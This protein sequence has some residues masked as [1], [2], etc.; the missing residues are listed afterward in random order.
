MH[1]HMHTH[2]I[3]LTTGTHICLLC[4]EAAQPHSRFCN[5][6]ATTPNDVPTCPC[7]V[8]LSGLGSYCSS[9]CA[10]IHGRNRRA[11]EPSLALAEAVEPADTLPLDVID[12]DDIDFIVTKSSKTPAQKLKETLASDIAAT[13]KSVSAPAA[14]AALRKNRKKVCTFCTNSTKGVCRCKRPLCGPCADDETG[15]CPHCADEAE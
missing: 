8:E 15:L 11:T 2:T 1:T 13:A 4:D 9:A 12:A 10:E 5:G 7:G 6:C 3:D 14:S